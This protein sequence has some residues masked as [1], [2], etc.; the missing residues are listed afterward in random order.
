MKTARILCATACLA[1]LGLPATAISGTSVALTT[2][3]SGWFANDGRDVSYAVANLE[4]YAVG[5][6][7]VD[8]SQ[9]VLL[10]DFFIFDLSTVAGPITSATLN[11][12]VPDKPPDSGYGY[13]SFEPSEPYQ[14]TS[15]SS[16]IAGL[17]LPYP[18]GSSLGLAIYNT[19]GTGTV[20]AST[21][22]SPVDLGT[23]IHIT[24]NAA[25]LAFLNSN[26]GLQIALS[27]QDPDAPSS[28][29]TDSTC[30]TCRFFFT[31][32]DPTGSGTFSQTPKPSL[33][34]TLGSSA[35]PVPLL[36]AWGVGVLAMLVV[37]FAVQRLMTQA[38]TLRP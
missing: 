14:V 28:G 4:N 27:G 21:N 20:F 8:F 25:A 2:V 15:T 16:S 35:T 37:W 22:V 34:L 26:E 3:K 17:S 31:A 12:Y 5:W 33:V 18:P 23:T 19:L 13:D 36:S 24:L 10:R 6:D 32:T 1:G 7:P 29:P 38:A 30:R 11:L 9:G